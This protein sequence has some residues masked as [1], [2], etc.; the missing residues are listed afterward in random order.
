MRKSYKGII[1]LSGPNEYLFGGPGL[2][3]HGDGLELF[4][5]ESHGDGLEL[6]WVVSTYYLKVST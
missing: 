4:R 3:S 1:N 5:V 2:E 6:F